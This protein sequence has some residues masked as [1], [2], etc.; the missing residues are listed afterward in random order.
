MLY[1]SESIVIL[2]LSDNRVNTPLNV[3]TPHQEKKKQ[4]Q[5]NPK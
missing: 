1:E 3:T 2:L 4:P 5:V